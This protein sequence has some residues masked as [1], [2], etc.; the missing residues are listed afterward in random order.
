MTKDQIM[1][2]FYSQMAL[3]YSC[4][5][6]QIRD[7]SNYIKTDLHS[8]GSRK[9]KPQGHIAKIVSLNGKFVLCVDE[10]I[11]ISA[12]KLINLSGEWMSLSQSLEQLNV[13]TRPLGYV[14]MDE[15]HYYL[16]LGV[17]GLSEDTIAQ[18]KQQ[19][20]ITLYEKD[21]LEQF[22]GDSR[23]TAA[24]SF[25]ED[26]PDMLAITAEKEGEILGMSGASADSESM[27]QIGIN[28]C[29][30]ARGQNIGPFLTILL[31]DEIMRRG[32]LPFYGT[33][34]S[35]IQSQRVALKSGF[36]PTWWEAYSY[37]LTVGNNGLVDNR[38]ETAGGLNNE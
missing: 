36:I 19:Y 1:N 30:N 38:I 16:P 9:F 18:M 29:K 5:N 10:S 33:A 27:W 15:H 20:K 37:K 3:D 25:C 6:E 14:A 13:I 28:V 35:H 26:A 11:K 24:L 22:R 7:Y 31:K 8:A 21:E 32:K 12:E 34:E 23:F 2:I 17:N 4:S